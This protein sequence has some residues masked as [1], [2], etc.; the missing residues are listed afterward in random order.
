MHADEGVRAPFLT[1]A[2]NKRASHPDEDDHPVNPVNPVQK[3]SMNSMLC[4]RIYAVLSDDNSN[5][6][7]S[8]TRQT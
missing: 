7:T 4:F 5:P 8:K 6:C 1:P 2:Q 3:K